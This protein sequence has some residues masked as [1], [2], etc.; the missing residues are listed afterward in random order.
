MESIE[1]RKEVTISRACSQFKDWYGATVVEVG[2]TEYVKFKKG[3]PMMQDWL[4]GRRT[5]DKQ[6]SDVIQVLM[7]MQKEATTNE[8]LQEENMMVGPKSSHKKKAEAAALKKLSEGS[9]SS[10]V[11]VRLPAITYNGVSLQEICTTMPL[12]LKPAFAAIPPTPENLLW[13]FLKCQSMGKHPKRA[14]S[15]GGQEEGEE[16]DPASK[17]A[18]SAVPKVG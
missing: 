17:K 1:V 4:V 3:D 9:T 12:N 7:D 2:G 18:A 16:A 8:L 10:C 14:R 15:Q 13:V 11:Q 6:A 5:Y